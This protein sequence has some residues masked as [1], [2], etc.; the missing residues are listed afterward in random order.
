MDDRASRCRRCYSQEPPWNLGL[1]ATPEARHNQSIAHV[2]HSPCNK[3]Q[4]H[5]DWQK[6][7]RTR[8]TANNALR[9]KRLA[10]VDTCELCHGYFQKFFSWGQ[11]MHPTTMHHGDY[12][13]VLDVVWVCHYCHRWRGEEVQALWEQR[14]LKADAVCLLAYGEKKL[15]EGR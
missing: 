15:G 10:R 3:G 2:G 14:F 4:R 1:R 9:D 13:R 8:W 5:P 12:S 6:R 11:R 7:K